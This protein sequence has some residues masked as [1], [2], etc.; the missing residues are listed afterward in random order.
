MFNESILFPRS[1]NELSLEA[2]NDFTTY[3]Y[4][5][6]VFGRLEY[7]R[8]SLEQATQLVYFCSSDL[9]VPAGGVVVS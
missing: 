4:G 7:E 5:S 2:C 3:F 6:S 8:F 1:I 9:L